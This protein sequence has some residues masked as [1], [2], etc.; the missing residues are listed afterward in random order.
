[1]LILHETEDQDILD[2][3]KKLLGSH[4]PQLL[5]RRRAAQ[6]EREEEGER[7]DGEF[8]RE[9]EERRATMDENVAALFLLILP[10][11]K[12]PTDTTAEPVRA[13]DAP[14]AELSRLLSTTRRHLYPQGRRTGPRGGWVG[15]L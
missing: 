4:V 13:R 8:Q 14:A 12:L 9:S 7:V 6:G 1:M 3:R 5:R 15:L 10:E 2:F 11:K